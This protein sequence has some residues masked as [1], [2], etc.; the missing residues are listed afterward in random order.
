MENIENY[1]VFNADFPDD[2]EEDSNGQI[3]TVAGRNILEAICRHISLSGKIV[4]KPEAYSFYGWISEFE[5][6]KFTI[7]LLLQKPGPWLL[8]LESKGSWLSARVTKENSLRQGADIVHSALSA[9][10]RIT[11]LHW[12]T[13]TKFEGRTQ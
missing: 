5:V 12:M 7:S 11:S 13:K 10:S 6:S 1:A 3:I 4:R 8:I 2:S 9:E